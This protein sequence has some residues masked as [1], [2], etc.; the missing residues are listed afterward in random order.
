M[1]STIFGFLS[2][3]VDAIGTWLT[4]MFASVISLIYTA[5][6]APATTGELTAFG[7]LL[8]IG[9][10]VSLFFFVLRWVIALV[11]FRIGGSR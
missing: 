4:T 3:G 6:V 10:I 1:L 2:E 5:P 9:M 8:F 11:K 7:Q